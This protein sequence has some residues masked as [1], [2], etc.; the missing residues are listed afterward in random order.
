VTTLFTGILVFAFASSLHALVLRVA[1][2]ILRYSVTFKRSLV[3]GSV[4]SP[5]FLALRAIPDQNLE[6]SL[7]LAIAALYALPLF[8]LLIGWLF[9]EHATTASGQ[10]LGWRGTIRLSLCAFLVW[11]LLWGSLIWAMT[12]MH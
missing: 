8:V 2:R 4:I 10:I 5:M 12:V 1:A 6:Y 9:R 11:V 7:R 3:F